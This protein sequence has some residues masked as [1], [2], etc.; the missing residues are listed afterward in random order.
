LIA[1]GCPHGAGRAAAWGKLTKEGGEKVD[2]A[3]FP[4]AE[5]RTCGAFWPKIDFSTTV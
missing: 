5:S 2:F 3:K 1:F 4:N